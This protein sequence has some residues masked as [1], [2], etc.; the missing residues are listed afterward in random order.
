MPQRA[1]GINVFDAGYERM[2]TLYKEGHRVV[3]SFSAGKD[4]TA[5]LEMCYLAAKD[6]GRL[7]LEAITRDEEIMLPGTYEYTQRVYDRP[8]IDLC[9]MTQ[10]QP[11]INIFNREQ[12]YWW[13]FDDEVDQ[14]LWVRQPPPFIKVFPGLSIFRMATPES[15][16]PPE[17]KE[18]IV[19]VGLRVAESQR[20]RMG[21]QSSRG[22]LTKKNRFGYRLARP[23]YDWEDADIWKFIGDNKFDYND[24]YD[25]MH[26]MGFPARQLRIAPPTMSMKSVQYLE[27]GMKAWPQWFDRVNRRLP[28]VRTVA[29]FGKR[30]VFVERRVGETW[31]DCYQRACIDEA[32]DWIRERAI[33]VREKALARHAKHSTDPFPQNK[34]CPRCATTACWRTIARAM[35][36]GDPWGYQQDIFTHEIDPEFFRPG[37]G[38]WFGKASF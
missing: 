31:E 7:P 30:A 15:Y 2:Y 13:V 37:A 8:D 22:F 26:R 10:K 16:P 28:G 25:V 6:A 3:V 12:P 23:L 9:W 4:S 36:N 19:V 24:A 11:I 27:L 14:E 18:L 17:G 38:K 29:Q 21:I 5:I 1:L 32:P 20:R 34:P 33:I 35:Y